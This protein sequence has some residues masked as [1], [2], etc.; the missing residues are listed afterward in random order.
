M[1]LCIFDFR[2][3]VLMRLDGMSYIRLYS[4]T[5]KSLLGF[6]SCHLSS[7]FVE[8]RTLTRVMEAFLYVT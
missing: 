6:V 4:M 1:V 5:G 2:G 8:C 7:D 3:S